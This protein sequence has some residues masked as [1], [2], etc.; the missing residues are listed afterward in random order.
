[1]LGK[2]DIGLSLWSYTIGR[3][4]IGNI[5]YNFDLINSPWE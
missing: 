5:Y 2:P 1:M 3:I 4:P